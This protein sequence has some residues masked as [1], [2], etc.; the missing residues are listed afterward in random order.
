[1]LFIDFSSAFKKII[2]Q[3]LI[4]KLSLLGLNTSLYSW[5]LDFLTER[6][7]SVRIRSSI[8][9]T[10]TLSAGAL[11]GLCAQSTAVHSADS[12][13]L[14]TCRCLIV[15]TTGSVR[16]T[17]LDSL[18]MEAAITWELTARPRPPEPGS[19]SILMVAFSVD[20]KKPKFLYSTKTTFT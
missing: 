20:R 8:S 14:L 16:N 4:G 1:M 12:R 18:L 7:Q 3:Y 10:T 13:L 5:I 6:S 19:T 15:N 2:P 17:R 9:N 11:P